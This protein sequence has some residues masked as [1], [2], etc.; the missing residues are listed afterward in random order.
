MSVRLVHVKRNFNAAA[1]YLTGKVLR[2][3]TSLV[4]SDPDELGQLAQLNQLPTR[5]SKSPSLA[6]TPVI[7]QIA[8]GIEPEGAMALLV[9]RRIKC[10]SQDPAKTARC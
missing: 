10:S 3:G 1:D 8:S 5:M 2:L 6:K 7:P 4:I 9:T